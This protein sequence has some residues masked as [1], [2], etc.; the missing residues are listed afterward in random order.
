MS[1]ASGPS[2]RRPDATAQPAMHRLRNYF[3]TGLI[4]AAPLFLTV[5]I[6]WSFVGWIDGWVKPFIPARY[7][8]DTYLPFAV[9]GF[10]LIVALLVLTLLGFLTANLVGRTLVSLGRVH[11]S[12]ACRSSATSIGGL[13]QIFETVL[14]SRATS[15][16]TVGLVEYPRKGVWSIVFV[17]ARTARRDQRAARRAGRSDDR[18]LPAVHAEPDDRLPPVRAARARCIVST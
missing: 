17:A 5:Y 16:R 8:P 14:S 18:G 15:F 4:V 12:A 10:G 11:R 2:S 6:T 13:K 9:P 3:L 7:R 1:R